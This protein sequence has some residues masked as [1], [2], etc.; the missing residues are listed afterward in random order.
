MEA[1]DLL[2]PFY[3]DGLSGGT[4]SLRSL[5]RRARADSRFLLTIVCF[6]TSVASGPR[7][8][9]ESFTGAIGHCCRTRLPGEPLP[10]FRSFLPAAA[11][12]AAEL[13]IERFGYNGTFSWHETYARSWF[14]CGCGWPG[15]LSRLLAQLLPRRNYRVHNLNRHATGP[16]HPIELLE[17][18]FAH[19]LGKEAHIFVTDYAVHHGGAVA[20]N[21]Q[22]TQRIHELQMESELLL[23]KL[24][25]LPSR[26]VVIH[27]EL[28]FSGHV[29][30]TAV[31]NAS[32]T[33]SAAALAVHRAFGEPLS[34]HYSIPLVS[35]P[36]VIA[37]ATAARGDLTAIE[38]L[39][40]AFRGDMAHPGQCIHDI[41]AE[42]ILQMLRGPRSAQPSAVVQISSRARGIHHAAHM[43][44]T[45]VMPSSLY[46]SSC[47]EPSVLSKELA[48]RFERHADGAR[49]L[50]KSTRPEHLSAALSAT[51][52][53]PSAHA[54]SHR[55]AAVNPNCPPIAL[56]RPPHTSQAWRVCVLG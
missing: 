20:R 26:P 6:S 27:L 23:R 48:R 42:L 50:P 47:E 52:P 11:A 4:R 22:A 1:A 13:S 54:P 45:P 29:W 32:S 41:A 34:R 37:A 39:G 21:G 24:L 33:A 25:G 17:T 28:P 16:V 2:R 44:L 51:A 3:A 38:C 55:P 8:C 10:S 30:K 12:R 49:D 53:S 5:I 18:S 15:R 46:L 31:Q 43:Q 7:T 36:A 40:R 9:V 19:G 14:D 35:V 56:D